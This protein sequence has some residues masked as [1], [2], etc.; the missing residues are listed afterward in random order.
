MLRNQNG[1]FTAFNI[2]QQFLRLTLQ[3]GNK[4]GTH[5]AN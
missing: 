5:G 4:F 2:G 1:L 3:C